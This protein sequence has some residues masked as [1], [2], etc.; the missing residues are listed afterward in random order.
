M[1]E[2]LRQ[3][4]ELILIDTPPVLPVPD[5]L[6][7]GQW[8]DGSLIAVRSDT[9]RF[10]FV[11]RASRLLA[12]ARIP[13]LGVVVNGVRIES[14]Y[15]DYAYRY[16]HETADPTSEAASSDAHPGDGSPQ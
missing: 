15:A 11:G 1:I 6:T 8:V 9:S 14:T 4:F 3:D 10:H 2:H 16:V 5:A 13:L 7:I 12:S